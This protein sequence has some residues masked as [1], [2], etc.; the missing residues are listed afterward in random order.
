MATPVVILGART[1]AEE[2][3][4]LISEMPGYEVRAFVENMDRD[5]CREPLA[6]LP[7]LWVDALAM[8]ET[9]VQAI[10]GL[11][12]TQRRRYVEQVHALGVPFATLLHPRARVSQTAELGEGCFLSPFANVSVRSKLG[13]HVFVNRGVL[14]GHHTTIGDFCSIHPGANIAGKVTIGEQTYIGMG[15]IIRDGVTIG[16]GCVIAAGAVVTRDL[17]DHVLVMGVPAQIVQTGIE[18]K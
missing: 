15:A 14:I 7:V 1:L 10:C 6:G 16:S 11:A 18:A 17:P 2:I 3:A 4:D 12:T 13:Q 5:R 8:L 9:G